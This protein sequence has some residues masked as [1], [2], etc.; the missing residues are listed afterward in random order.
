M[1]FSVPLSQTLIS[2]AIVLLGTL[3]SCKGQPVSSQ[4]QTI[5][6]GKIGGSCEGC[7]LI[8]VGMPAEIKAVDTS[9]GWSEKGQRLL[10]AGTIYQADGETPAQGVVL[11]YWQTDVNGLYTPAAG[12]DQLTLPHGHIRGWVKT[13]EKGRYEIYTIRPGAYPR[14]S[15]P[16]HVHFFLLEPGANEAYYTEDLNFDDDPLLITHLKKYLPE[17]RGGSGIARILLR[18]GIQVAEHDIILGLNIPNH[19]KVARTGSGLAVGEDQPSFIPYHAYGPDKGTR[20]CPVCKYGRYHGLLYFVGNRPDWPAIRSWLTYL[21][22]ESAI[23]QQRKI[24]R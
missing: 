13:D 6:K 12:Q 9:A 21:E 1:I 10:I 16:A 18:D 4:V 8:F 24:L 17:N 19:P 20:T 2:L 23:R 22:K 11:Y 3:V 5:S 15:M 14:E 7:E